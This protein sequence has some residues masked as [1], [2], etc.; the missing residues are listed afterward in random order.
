MKMKKEVANLN[1]LLVKLFGIL[2]E[3]M[4]LTLLISYSNF[5][6]HLDNGDGT[7]NSAY[8]NL[9]FKERLSDGRN[10]YQWALDSLI[11]DKDSRQAIITF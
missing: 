1:I 11:D 5:W 6:K 7:V 2:Q 10:Q 8:G 4:I 3:G 9:I